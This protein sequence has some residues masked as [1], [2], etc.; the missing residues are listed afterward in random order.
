MKEIA[1]LLR[2]MQ[3]FAHN[4]HNMSKGSLFLQDHDYLGELYPLYEADYD[5]VVERMIGLGQQLD[6][7]E[8]QVMAVEQLKSLPSMSQENKELFMLILDMEK[9]L[10]SLIEAMIQGIKPSEGT[11]QLLGDIC[12]NSEMRQYKLGQRVRK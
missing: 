8:V 6:L 2:T 9:S 3:L 7:L 4:A 10:C 11:K 12:N 1:I 5:S